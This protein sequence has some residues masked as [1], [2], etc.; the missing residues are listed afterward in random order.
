MYALRLYLPTIAWS[1]FFV[2]ASITF[3]DAQTV[4][5]QG[6]WITDRGAMTLK[7]K[8]NKVTGSYKTKGTV[9]GT[10]AGDTVKV[11][12]RNG[13]VS[14]QGELKVSEGNRSF[15]GT[16]SEQGQSSKWRGWKKDPTAESRDTADFSGIWLSSWGVMQLEQNGD[17]V[18]GSYGPEGWSSL[19]GTVKGN[20]LLLTWKRI[21]WSGPA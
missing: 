5:W 17:K 15:E 8:G 20:R 18:K 12:Y 9:S 3:S 14:G 11:N 13:R 6:E 19:E 10:I 21:H 2:L 16:W 7:Q 4:D 1:L